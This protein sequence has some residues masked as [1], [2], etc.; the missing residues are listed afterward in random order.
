MCLSD[1]KDW[2]EAAW[3]SCSTAP[4]Y[5]KKLWSAEYYYACHVN[6]PDHPQ[7][8]KHKPRISQVDS[9][10]SST[11]HQGWST[12]AVP[13]VR[14]EFT[15]QSYSTSHLHNPPKSCQ[16]PPKSWRQL[17]KIQ[18]HIWTRALSSF[19][20][21][22][23]AAWAGCIRPDSILFHNDADPPKNYRKP[24]RCNICQN[25]E[26]FQ[27]QLQFLTCKPLEESG[28][29]KN[30]GS[31]WLSAWGELYQT[32]KPRKWIQNQAHSSPTTR[33]ETEI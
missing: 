21:V 31:T 32:Q 18:L 8:Q 30:F 13:E 1:L 28:C 9:L 5:Q 7:P 6:R 19:G 27:G 23:L 16:N 29:H 11:H 24:Q 15:L 2:I 12:R 22:R 20:S 17:A 4:W 14:D 25:L 33:T 3:E 26:R 10:I